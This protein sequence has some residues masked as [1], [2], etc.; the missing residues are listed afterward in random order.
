[1]KNQVWYRSKH[2]YLRV[3]LGVVGKVAQ[4]IIEH[5]P[6]TSP[7][8][9]AVT[10]T[11]LLSANPAVDPLLNE[12]YE[13]WGGVLG[14]GASLSFSFPWIN[15]LSA[16]WQT[17][18]YSTAD[19]P[20]ATIHSG[21]NAIQMTAARNALQAWANV[22]N[23]NFSE[24]SETNTSVGDFRFAFSSAI[25]SGAWGNAYYPSDYWASAA[26]VWINPSHRNDTNWSSGAYNYEALMHEI[27]H[28]LGL[29]HP[30]NYDTDGAGTAGP[31]LQ[32][33]QDY[34]NYTIMSYNNPVNSLFV[35]VTNSN[36]SYSWTSYNINPDTP[37]LYDVAAIQYLY[38]VNTTYHSGNDIY[39]FDPTAPFYRTIWDAG[40][41]DSISVS[42]FTKACTIDLNAGHFSKI[43]IESDTSPSGINWAT[44][45]PT[46]G[47]YDGSNNLAIAFGVTIENAIGGSGNDS[48]IGNSINN[49]L[50]GGAGNDT[51]FGGGG[52]D[53][54]D[55]GTGIDT[56]GYSGKSSE[57]VVTYNIATA[58]Y[59]VRD[60]VSGRDGSDTL[61]SVDNLQ[62]SDLTGTSSSFISLSQL[63]IFMPS[64]SPEA[65]TVADSGVKLYA[66]SA[67][68]AVTINSGVYSVTLDQNSDR[69]NLPGA[70]SN[71]KF[72]QTGNLLTVYD[73]ATSTAI[74]TL[75]V[76]GDTDG[77]QICFSNGTSYD[78]KFVAGH[79]LIGG[80]TVDTNTAA[81]I[82][83]SIPTATAAP[84]TAALSSA[85]IFMGKN[86]LINV[87]NGGTT[88]Y[89][90]IGAEVLTVSP[91]TTNINFDQNVDQINFSGAESNYKFLQT[92]NQIRIYDADGSTLLAKGP[93]QGDA[94]GTLLMFS[95]GAGSAMMGATG[96]V[97]L[98]GGSAVSAVAPAAVISS[99][100]LD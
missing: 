63:K 2:N 94:D 4:S 6:M 54:L 46:T 26:D 73:Y 1:M 18:F 13:K 12:V 49:N 29:K 36:N 40:G 75:P 88:V 24:V 91:G 16:S 55:G 42:N 83:P 66:G 85:R 31:Y 38:G 27:G 14:S 61:V 69:I 86:D 45:P 52:N 68:D 37:M 48:L 81:T 97:M 84:T 50:S 64:Q 41:T 3:L 71:F 99:V 90:N 51:F 70:V 76:Q 87:A 96:G 77:T 93:V 8:T 82:I 74:V 65:F 25:S 10:N 17:P 43:T 72:K 98:L 67:M 35:S 59:T 5:L 28:G 32:A 95:N 62:F 34:R 47:L 15:G 57:Y 19:E 53:I 9:S 21:F 44:P 79:V 100:F 23:I 11:F 22:A 92:G 60:T 78:A 39:T 7:N 33:S 58:Q 30:G 20:S 89:G 56:A 80:A